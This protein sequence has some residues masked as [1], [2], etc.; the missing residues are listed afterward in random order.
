MAGRAGD[1]LPP[2]VAATPGL[3]PRRATLPRL[4]WIGR[5]RADDASDVAVETACR[6][7]P[8]RLQPG[9]RVVLC[10]A[11][12]SE[13]EAVG[14]L[15]ELLS[16]G[17]AESAAQTLR[18]LLQV[19][20][21]LIDVAVGVVDWPRERSAGT[22]APPASELLNDELV[23]GFAE[24]LTALGEE[25]DAAQAASETDE[26]APQDPFQDGDD[27]DIFAAMATVLAG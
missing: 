13:L 23:A 1:P 22:E 5:R 8:T 26:G 21:G 7:A 19:R 4:P 20:R 27:D 11:P 16:F 18:D 6:T 14:G 17:D 25:L 9:D 2:L 10:S 15:F 12:L 3:V 24:V